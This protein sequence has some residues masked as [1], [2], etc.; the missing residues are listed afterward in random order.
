MENATPHK[1]NMRMADGN[2]VTL[3]CH[4]K[5]KS[6][7]SLAREYARQ[8]YPD[9]YAVFTEY[10]SSTSITGTSI[11]E[12]SYEH[13]VFISCILRPALFPSQV[14]FMGALTAVALANG[15]EAHTDK[16]LGIGWVSDIYCE[17]EKIGGTTTEGKLDAFNS[18]EYILVTF[19]IKLSKK[20]FPP[21]LKDLIA[22]VFIEENISVP[23]I[24]AKDILTK[25]FSLYPML[26]TPSK[27]FEE[28]KKRFILYDQPIKEF[29]DGKRVSCKVVDVD[30]NGMLVISYPNGTQKSLYTPANL[31]IPRKI[32]LPKQP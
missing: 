28:Y 30:D 6:A 2:I 17:G 1:V 26:R 22:N 10:Q 21:T 3:E 18:Y 13:G 5:L 15:L 11:R 31:L 4:D 14:G 27:F 19:A 12:G 23:M 8:G 29:A 7:V 20:Y 16:S 25:F 9:R 24:I 32:K